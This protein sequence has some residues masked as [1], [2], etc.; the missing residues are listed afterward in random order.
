LGLNRK[1]LYRQLVQYGLE[2]QRSH[3]A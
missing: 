1:T 3:Q 2:D